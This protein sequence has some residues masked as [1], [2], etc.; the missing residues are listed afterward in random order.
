MINFMIIF[1]MCFF[2]YIHLRLMT[3]ETEGVIGYKPNK[4]QFYMNISLDGCM[5]RN[6]HTTTEMDMSVNRY[7]LLYAKQCTNTFPMNR[8]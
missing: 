7:A 3:S 1:G 5:E 4:S 6:E 8:Y 2:V